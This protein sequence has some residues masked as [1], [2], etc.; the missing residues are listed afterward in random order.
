M[1]KSTGC[2][3]CADRSHKTT[4]GESKTRLFH[5]WSGIKDRCLNERCGSYR[6]YGGRGISICAEWANDYAAFRDWAMANGYRETLTID[7]IQVEGNY[8]PGNCRW[9]TKSEQSNNKRSTIFVVVDGERVSL[10]QAARSQDRFSLSAVRNR[11]R[12]FGDPYAALGISPP[13]AAA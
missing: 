11:Y 7:R 1:G 3:K 9:A 10:T 2:A 6:D 8:E 12:K 13:K 4:H 5:I